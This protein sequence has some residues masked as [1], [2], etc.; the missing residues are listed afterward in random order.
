[1]VQKNVALSNLLI[2]MID[3]AD[4][5]VGITGETVNVSISKDGGAFV[6]ATNTPAISI[7]YGD[8]KINLTQT[9]MNADAIIVRGSSTNADVWTDYLF[10]DDIVADIASIET[11][12]ASIETDVAAIIAKIPTGMGRDTDGIDHDYGGTD[13][14]RILD[15]EGSPIPNAN[16]HIFL[17]SDWD[18]GNRTTAYVAT[19]GAWSETDTDG[20]WKFSVSLNA[21]DYIIIAQ[22][23]GHTQQT[24][25]EFTVT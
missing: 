15:G 16:L 21:E 4:R 25:T 24:E 19:N 18:A 13:N 12:V 7:A 11:D 17:K 20:R 2:H 6:A 9:E 23:P 8:Y 22:I 10:P 1:M 14:L 3:S 5:P